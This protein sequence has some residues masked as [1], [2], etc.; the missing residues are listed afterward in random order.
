M[1]SHAI[2][3]LGH[4]DALV[5][6]AGLNAPLGTALTNDEDLWRRMI[7][8][9][10]SGPWWCTKALLEHFLERGGSRVVI[11][12]S[13]A[14]WGGS[15]EVAAAYSAAKSGLRGLVTAPAPAG[16]LRHPGECDRPGDHL[17]R[18]VVVGRGADRTR[19]G[20]TV[21]SGRHGADRADVA[22]LLGPGG[23]WISGAI[24][25]VSGGITKGR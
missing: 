15:D 8:V 4:V 5:N 9:A 10:L 17:Y 3:E 23:A 11:I 18:R 12:S 21:G 16:A 19:A 6:I 1:A 2:A 20:H 7:D 24:L 25:N 22:H 14:A 13:G